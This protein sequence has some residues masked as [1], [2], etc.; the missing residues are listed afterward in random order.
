VA[1]LVLHN[2]LSQQE[3]VR[4]DRIEREKVERLFQRKRA[5]LPEVYV[6]VDAEKEPPKPPPPSRSRPGRGESPE[7]SETWS[8]S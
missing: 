7:K 3:Q 6:L 5:E 8:R 1:I 4:L 2:R